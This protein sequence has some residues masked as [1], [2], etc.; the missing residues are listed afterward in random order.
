M[1][2]EPCIVSRGDIVR[3]QKFP[4]GFSTIAQESLLLGSFTE[5]PA[6]I[7]LQIRI[8]LVFPRVVR[9]VGVGALLRDVQ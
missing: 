4:L 9:E 8:L 2:L 6:T 1:F 3:A 7:R 5:G